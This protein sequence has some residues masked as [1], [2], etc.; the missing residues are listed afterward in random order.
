MET[1]DRIKVLDEVGSGGIKATKG[2]IGLLALFFF[3]KILSFYFFCLCTSAECICGGQRTPCGNYFP[4]S[5]GD[6]NS[7][8]QA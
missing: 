3:K 4:V 6:Q 7:G 2:F 1:L 5:S 8:P